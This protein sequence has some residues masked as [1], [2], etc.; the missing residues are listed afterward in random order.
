MA[1]MG[2]RGTQHHAAQ[3]SHLK[4]FF[5][6]RFLWESTTT[7]TSLSSATTVSQRDA[8]FQP[9]WIRS[10]CDRQGSLANSR[11]GKRASSICHPSIHTA[12]LFLSVVL[13]FFVPSLSLQSS[14]FSPHVRNSSSGQATTPQL[15]PFFIPACF[16]LPWSKSS[17][18]E[19]QC[20]E[21]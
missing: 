10:M 6:S 19:H 3:K 20:S 9:T 17:S 7:M 12:P 1:A 8:K 16:S 21:G 4:G 15:T 14:L 2:K 5:L 13:S 18:P 11:L